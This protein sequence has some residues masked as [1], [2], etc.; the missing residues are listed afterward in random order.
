MAITRIGNHVDAMWHK[1]GVPFAALKQPNEIT[2]Q[3]RGFVANRK[4]R[5][6]FFKIIITS[7]HQIYST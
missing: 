4:N 3:V 7:C 2:Q 5:D 1:A 6:E